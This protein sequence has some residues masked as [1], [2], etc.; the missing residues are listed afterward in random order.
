MEIAPKAI[1]PE[2]LLDRQLQVVLVES[3][4]SFREA[5]LRLFA[6][7][8]ALLDQILNRNAARKAYGEQTCSLDP[9]GNGVGIVGGF[10][11]WFNSVTNTLVHEN[12]HCTIQLTPDTFLSDAEEL[13]EGI[14]GQ[15]D[16][17]ARIAPTV[18]HLGIIPDNPSALA[19]CMP[20]TGDIAVYSDRTGG[21][22]VTGF[23]ELTKAD[24]IPISTRQIV[25]HEFTCALERKG[26][27]WEPS[28]T[29]YSALRAE[30]LAKRGDGSKPREVVRSFPGPDPSS[31]RIDYSSDRV[32]CKLEFPDRSGR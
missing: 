9:I 1:K 2:I 22:L 31:V 11:F 20:A 7:E 12:E 28:S 27:V 19:G 16:L 10:E 23:A 21:L 32:A 17:L 26:M 4:A 29:A 8:R 15:R 25:I 24:A 18:I 3:R 5:A 14:Y 13:M 6:L 30:P